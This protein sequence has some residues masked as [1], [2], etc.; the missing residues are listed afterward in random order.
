[1]VVLALISGLALGGIAAWI[2]A[3]RRAGVVER[4]L[5]DTRV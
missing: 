1:M 4:Q 3:T 2:L 5:G